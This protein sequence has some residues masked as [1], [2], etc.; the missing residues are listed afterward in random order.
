MLNIF[1]RAPSIHR[2]YFIFILYVVVVVVVVFIF[3]FPTKIE[4]T[5]KT[6]ISSFKVNSVMTMVVV[7]V[8]MMMIYYG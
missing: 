8:E 7:V 4:L 5:C 1:G 2:Y 6:V 3:Y